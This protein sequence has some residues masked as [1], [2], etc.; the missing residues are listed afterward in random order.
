MSEAEHCSSL[1]LLDRGTVLD[2]GAP[3]E[4]VARCPIHTYRITS[5]AAALNVPRQRADLG[6]MGR[7]YAVAGALHVA[8]PRENPPPPDDVFARVRTLAP[9]AERIDDVEPGVEDLF[10]YYLTGG[11]AEQRPGGAR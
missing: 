6:P 7:V 3:G 4:M 9:E 2:H 1:L 11:G 10:F 8:A 5:S